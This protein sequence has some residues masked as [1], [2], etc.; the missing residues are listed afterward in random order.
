MTAKAGRAEETDVIIARQQHG[1]HVS[2]AVD[3]NAPIE[4]AVFSMRSF[5]VTV[6]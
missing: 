3:T 5:V 1:K 4:D 2:A 6:R